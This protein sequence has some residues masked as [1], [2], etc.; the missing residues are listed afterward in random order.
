MKYLITL[1]PLLV[2]IAMLL[3]LNKKEKW[4]YEKK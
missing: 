3:I 2:I 4:K 1:L